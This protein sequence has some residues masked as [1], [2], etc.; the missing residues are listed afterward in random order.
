MLSK[1]VEHLGFSFMVI[2]FGILH[3]IATAIASTFFVL[4]LSRSIL[5]F[6][7][8]TNIGAIRIIWKLKQRKPPDKD[9]L[10]PSANLRSLRFGAGSIRDLHFVIRCDISKSNLK[11]LRLG[12]ESI[13]ANQKTSRRFQF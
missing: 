6:S 2:V 10:T 7:G 9:I 13:I 1:M 3:R 11:S 5:Q 12:E 8:S 4:I